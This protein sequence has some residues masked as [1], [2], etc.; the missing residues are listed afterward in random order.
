[1]R[2]MHGCCA[3]HFKWLIVWVYACVCV[4]VCVCLVCFKQMCLCNNSSKLMIH[5]HTCGHV[6]HTEQ[7]PKQWGRGC[8][9]VSV[10]LTPHFRM[11]V[12]VSVWTVIR[13]RRLKVRR[14]ILLYFSF[15]KFPSVLLNTA[16][17]NQNFLLRKWLENETSPAS[18][19]LERRF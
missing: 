11:C 8:Q 18:E 17:K 7:P 15:K 14:D 16:L 2:S 6:K 12:C 13:R 9:R 5:L 19:L 10:F 3:H 1:M 4:S